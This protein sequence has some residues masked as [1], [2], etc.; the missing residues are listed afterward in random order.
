[1]RQLLH[2][3]Y[4]LTRDARA[5]LMAY[6]TSISQDNFTRSHP[7]VGNGGSIGNLLVH[8][9]N[10]YHGWLLKFAFKEPFQKRTFTD[11]ETLKDCKDYF[12]LTDSLMN[13]FLDHFD[14]RYD[15]PLE[16]ELA[17]RNFQATPLQLFTHVVT[18]EF[19]HKG[20]ILVLG[21]MWGY[22]PVDTDVLR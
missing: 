19:H 8:I 14:H 22:E 17:S 10:S 4:Q 12:Q 16:G 9:N 5:V 20:Q 2:T 3:Q 18:H 13:R 11:M 21:R 15:Q 6:C 1:M 7:E